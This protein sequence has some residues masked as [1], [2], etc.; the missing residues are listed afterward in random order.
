MLK[1]RTLKAA[2]AGIMALSLPMSALAQEDRA[3]AAGYLATSTQPTDI[4]P[5]GLEDTPSVPD[6]DLA[7]DLVSDLV[8]DR[9]ADRITDRCDL[10]RFAAQ[11]DDCVTDQFPHDVDIRHLIHRLIHAGEWAKLVRLLNWLGWI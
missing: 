9:A 5:D 11:H 1:S 10:R 4:A 6:S 3:D 8:G 2:L 7:S